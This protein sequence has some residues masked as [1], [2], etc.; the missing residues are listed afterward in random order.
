MGS[1]EPEVSTTYGRVRGRIEHGNAVFRGLPFARPPLF[2]LR[3]QA[4]APPAPWDGVRDAGQFG[5]QSPQAA[6]PPAADTALAD[7]ALADRAPGD[8]T[9]ANAAPAD[10][11]PADKIGRAHV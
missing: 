1:A 7:P 9:R 6:F 5:P 10:S 8:T 2:G 4:P 11:A 3:F